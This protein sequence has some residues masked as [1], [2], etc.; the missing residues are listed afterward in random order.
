MKL[1]GPA[2]AGFALATLL[3]VRASAADLIVQPGQSIQAAID[4]AAEHDRVLVQP[5]TY[6]EAIDFL[7]KDIEVIGAGAAV[8]RIDASGLRTSVVRLVNGEPSTSRLAGF[9]I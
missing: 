8:T 2:A 6:R 9:T 5:G 1:D 7:G 3:A 4:A